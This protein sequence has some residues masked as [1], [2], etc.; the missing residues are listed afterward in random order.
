MVSW[1]IVMKNT[2]GDGSIGYHVYRQTV[3]REASEIFAKPPHTW[4]RE[5]AKFLI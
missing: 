4:G 5:A 3:Q 2:K 1:L